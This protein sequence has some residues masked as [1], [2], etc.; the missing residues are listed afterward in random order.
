MIDRI[1]IH[2]L[3]RAALY[4]LPPLVSY[5]WPLPVALE[6]FESRGPADATVLA[7]AGIAIAQAAA[8]PGY[9]YL[10]AKDPVRASMPHS[11]VRWINGSLLLQVIASA[12]LIAWM[13]MTWP[14]VRG[15]AEA[16]DFAG[17]LVPPAIAIVLAL[18]LNELFSRGAP[19]HGVRDE[20]KE[21]KP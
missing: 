14:S 20:E 17:W 10:V 13:L 12:A 19:L 9:L 3:A 16:V 6:A 8:L 5:R 1:R 2:R 7:L 11:R 18:W 15:R 4:A 21:T